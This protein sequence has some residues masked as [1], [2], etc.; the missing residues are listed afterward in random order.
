MD[1]ITLILTILAICTFSIAYIKKDGR[2]L[3]F[4][5]SLF[6][7]SALGALVTDASINPDLLYL[8]VIPLVSMLFICIAGFV[9]KPHI[10]V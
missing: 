9:A 5:G 8:L 10:E 2:G 7:T 4:L 1:E 3:Y 6:T